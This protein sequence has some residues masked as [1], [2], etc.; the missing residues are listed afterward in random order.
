MDA[1]VVIT[2]VRSIIERSAAQRQDERMQRSIASTLYVACTA[3]HRTLFGH[4][5]DTTTIVTGDSMHR[6]LCSALAM[7]M[8]ALAW[9]ADTPLAN[10]PATT[11]AVKAAPQITGYLS[12]ATMPSSAALV[13][14]PPAAGSAAMVR[15]ED[16]SR[17]ALALYGTPR[18]QLAAQDAVLAFPAVAQ[19]FSCALGVPISDERTPR[20]MTLLRRTLIDAGRST[21][22]AKQ[23]YQRARPFM[24]NG[25]PMCT[26]DRDAAL[27]ADGSYPSGHSAIGWAFGLVLSEVSPDQTTALIARG[28]AFGQ[29]RVA[30]NVHWQSDVLEGQLVASAVV[31]R[32]HAEP[33]FR[34]DVDAARAE[35]AALRTQPLTSSRDCNAESQ[36]LQSWH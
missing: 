22:E 21:R 18:W 16:V 7:F 34:N 36:A 35:L 11:S 8:A 15:D 25:K 14:E 28:R 26:P 23:R 9:S 27:R 3:I 4:N 30:C 10:G 2:S 5:A 29:S 17:S 31:A 6:A 12:P 1:A 33:A 19:S 13:P 20:L 32:M 24:V